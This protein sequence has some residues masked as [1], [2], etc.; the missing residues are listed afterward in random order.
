MEL[1]ILGT[2]RAMRMQISDRR[3]QTSPPTPNLAHGTKQPPA[4]RSGYRSCTD[5]WYWVGDVAPKPIA[6]ESKVRWTGVVTMVVGLDQLILGT[7]GVAGLDQLML[8]TD[9]VAGSSAVQARKVCVPTPAIGS[10]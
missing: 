2:D 9:G 7:D 6:T 4:I 8:G 5:L 3:T 1:M 10:G